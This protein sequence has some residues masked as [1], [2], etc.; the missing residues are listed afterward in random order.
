MEIDLLASLPKPKRDLRERSTVRTS[1]HVR[2]SRQYGQEYFDGDRAYGYGG[3][4]Y[5]GRWIPVAQDIMSHFGLGSGARVLDV[6][7][8][9]GFLVKDMVDL[10]LDAYGLDVSAYAVRNCPVEIAGRLQIGTADR[11]PF[12]DATFDAVISINTIHNLDRQKCVHALSE[13]QRVS[14]GCSFVQVDS[15][16]TEEQRKVF[17]DWVLTA[18][19]HGYPDDWQKVFMEAGYSGDWFWTIID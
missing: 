17:E 11:L 18:E 13:I 7:C 8:A 12:A 2:I 5:D 19:F 1:E 9:K 3:Y 4:H 6:G 10:G 16:R 14:R 15:Y